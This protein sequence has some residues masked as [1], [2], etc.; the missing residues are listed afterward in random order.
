M[1][2]HFNIYLNSNHESLGFTGGLDSCDER[3]QK[4]VDAVMERAVPDGVEVRDKSD[5]KFWQGG[6]GRGEKV[7][8][9]VRGYGVVKYAEIMENSVRFLIG[10][11]SWPTWPSMDQIEKVWEYYEATDE[12][13]NDLIVEEVERAQE[14]DDDA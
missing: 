2:I 5:F 14:E 9:Y 3:I 1:D 13:Y 12:L 7:T 11:G 6:P 10:D 4:C 8:L